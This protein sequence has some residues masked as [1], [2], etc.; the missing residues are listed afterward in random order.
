[1]GRYSSAIMVDADQNPTRKHVSLREKWAAED[2]A[3]AEAKTT[4]IKDVS[5]ISILPPGDLNQK[6]SDRLSTKMSPS[7]I[8]NY[9]AGRARVF[10]ESAIEYSEALSRIAGEIGAFKE[11]YIQADLN[12]DI[13]RLAYLES[14][15]RATPSDLVKIDEL[16]KK[17]KERQVPVLKDSLRQTYQLRY[18]SY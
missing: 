8:Q 9:A 10:E 2:A 15:G 5:E 4:A 12:I 13:G 1:M 14:E 18:T 16:E 7:S 6:E 17:S 3:K 11:S